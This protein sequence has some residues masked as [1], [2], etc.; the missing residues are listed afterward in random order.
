MVTAEPST[1]D[2]C[3]EL[4][5][6]AVAPFRAGRS[7]DGSIDEL[8][9]QMKQKGSQPKGPDPVTAQ[10]QTAKEIEQMKIAYN[11]ERDQAEMQLKQSELQQKDA[12]AK[13]QIES[14]ERLK[15][16]E[17]QGDAMADRAKAQQ[18]G[19]K[20]MHDREKHQADQIGRQLDVQTAT[21]KAALAQRTQMMKERDMSMRANERNAMHQQRIQQN[22]IRMM[23]PRGMQ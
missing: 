12:H 5:K 22:Q 18:T 8:V 23:Q 15:Q 2:F 16:Q 21:Q 9:E 19:L 1:A 17:L 7:M 14:D 6:F 11:K 10:S 3:G 4:L 13:L 20:M